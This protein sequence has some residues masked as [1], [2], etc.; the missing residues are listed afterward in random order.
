MEQ[1]KYRDLNDV[2]ET[3]LDGRDRMAIRNFNFMNK[4]QPASVGQLA[5]DLGF[6]VRH[7]ILP[8][9]VSGFLQPDTWSEKGFEIVVN[10][11]HPKVRQRFTALHEMA[12]YFL[13]SPR[14]EFLE[15]PLHRANSSVGFEKVY[16]GLE[17]IQE[18]EAN[19]WADAVVF[20]D[21][22]LEAASSMLARDIEQLSRHFGFSQQVILK[23]LAVRGL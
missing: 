5:Y 17:L 15:E 12:H 10:A 18:A 11:K 16:T 6:E 4:R 2:F 19:S 22:A 14:R 21:R 8:N 7:E 23:A 20:G 9:A 13:H 1:R 3:V